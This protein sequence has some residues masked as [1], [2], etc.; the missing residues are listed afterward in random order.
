M[1]APIVV[2]KQQSPW[3]Q[4]LPQ[5]LFMKIRHNMEME[6]EKL[7]LEA[8]KAEVAETRKYTEGREKE[9]GV[10]KAKIEGFEEAPLSQRNMFEKSGTAPSGYKNVYG[11]WL[12]KP[13]SEIRVDEKLG[14]AVTTDPT[15]KVT[16]HNL[17]KSE[18]TPEQKLQRDKDLAKY[19]ST[20]P[21]QPSAPR[22]QSLQAKKKLFK[23]PQTGKPMAWDYDYDSRTGKRVYVGKPYEIDST[24]NLLE[25]LFTGKVSMGNEEPNNPEDMTS[26]ELQRLQDLK[27]RY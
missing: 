6:Q 3:S 9:T 25:Q 11:T 19:K 1:G 23:D 20:L 26:E 5:L 17:P 7:R 18:E 16:L 21:N 15:G 27:S 14:V 2:N 10:A 22:K 24:F 8:K 4:Y 13:K 12:R